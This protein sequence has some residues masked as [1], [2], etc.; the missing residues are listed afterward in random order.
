LALAEITTQQI[1]NQKTN[2]HEICLLC[3]VDD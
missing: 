3:A 2:K 1:A